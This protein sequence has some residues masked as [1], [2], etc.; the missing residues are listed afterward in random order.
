MCRYCARARRSGSSAWPAGR[1][2]AFSER[3]IQLVTTFADQAVIA[4]ENA[5]LI[6]ELRQRTHDLQE[7]LEY[8]TATS[9][10]LKVISRSGAELEPV[11]ETLVETAAR[12]CEADKGVIVQQRGG[13]LHMAASFGFTPEFNEFVTR[14]PAPPGRGNISGRALARPAGCSR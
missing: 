12:I 4:I 3:E 14:H 13:L 5:R 11:L 7:L 6:T 9:D 10:V 1:V 2:E 8:Q